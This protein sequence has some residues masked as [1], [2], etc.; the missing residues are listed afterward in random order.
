MFRYVRIALRNSRRHWAFTLINVTGLGIGLGC[1]LL[2][3]LYVQNEMGYDRYH[4]NAG[5]ICR[6]GSELSFGGQTDW[7]ARTPQ[8]LGAALERE[9]PEIESAVRFRRD[10][11]IVKRGGILF[12]EDR[13]YYADPSVFSIFSFPLVEGDPKTALTAPNSIVLTEDAVRKYFG[14]EDPLGQ[15]LMVGGDEMNVTGVMKNVRQNSQFVFDFLASYATL[16]SRNPQQLQAWD[17]FVVSTYVLVRSGVPGQE[18]QSKLDAFRARHFSAADGVNRLVLNPLTDLHLWSRLPGEL[19]QGGSGTTLIVF[20]GVAFFIL[21]IAC[22]NFINLFVARA[23]NRMQEIGVRK[24]L[25][26]FRRNLIGQFLVE[27][28]VLVSMALALAV[29]AVELAL[30]ELNVLVGKE[31][32]PPGAGFLVPLV[33]VGLM[34]GLATGLYP[35]LF[36]SSFKPLVSLKGPDMSHGKPRF[37]SILVVGQFAISAALIASSLIVA[38]QMNFVETRDLGFK[39]D[40]VVIIPLRDSPALKNIAVL[41]HALLRSPDVL[42]ASA[43]YHTPTR[44]LGQYEVAVP[45][46]TSRPMATYIVDEDFVRTYGV[47]ILEGRDFSRDLP[48]DAS[49]AFLVNEAAVHSFGWKHALGKELVWDSHKRG[50]VIGVVKDFN[51]QS[52][53]DPIEPMV[54]HV[55]PDY[56]SYLSV[57]VRPSGVRSFL[58]YLSDEWHVIA[59]DVPLRYSFLD[60]DFGNQYRADEQ[61]AT[62]VDGSSGLGI[63]LACLG[64]VALTSLAVNRRTKEMG[65]RKVLGAHVGSIA[66]LISVDFL[67]LVAVANL[68]AVPFVLLAMNRWLENFAYHVQV[69]PGAFVLT[70]AATLLVSILSIAV[71]VLRAMR[72][73][74]VEALRYE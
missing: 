2:I 66:G 3:G 18:V 34:V 9:L 31:M 60:E 37:Q 25:G 52:L 48:S 72:V 59:P 26:A 68:V 33:G 47:K 63:L 7:T 58:G 12:R 24:V 6:V 57:R 22:I 71:F 30:P 70:M 67:K 19:G 15:P 45:G 46:K 16:K 29:V 39:K 51:I 20:S 8:P 74:P 40:H 43:T 4:A 13:F 11:P 50:R 49:S 42:N 73:N 44:G 38:N 14:D 32:P 28:V 61:L 23:S 69:G 53:H 64:L 54:I 55:D 5:R 17:N 36:L 21:L 62:M 10:H 27:S 41:K 65:I 1:C 56:F 35:A